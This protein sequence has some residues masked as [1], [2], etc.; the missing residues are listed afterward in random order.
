MNDEH[1]EWL[2]ELADRQ[3]RMVFAT[4]YRILGCAEDAEDV[5]QEV[6]LKLLASRNRRSKAEGVRD[7]GAYLR[8]MA[9]H[10]AVDLLR[11]RSKWKGEDME[12]CEE[13]PAPADHNPRRLA[14]QHQRARLLR[15]A[16][17][18]LPK[19]DARVF[20][21]RYFEELSY[22]KIAQ[23]TGLNI[24]AIGVVL[25]R[26]R[27]RLREILEPLVA[28]DGRREE[29]REKPTEMAKEDD[30]VTT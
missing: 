19:R 25:Y 18:T 21:L 23:Q 4:A 6:F 12:L 15:Q 1:A 17:S 3:G 27:N 9:A 16:V 7:W 14:I 2:A 13:M 29:N 8:V 5:L 11:R 26:A 24:N 20:A 30:H 10:C 28:R 22:E